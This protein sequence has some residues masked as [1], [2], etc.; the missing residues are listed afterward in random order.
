MGAEETAPQHM[1]S[2]I[3]CLAA[4]SFSR[5]RSAAG[6]RGAPRPAPPQGRIPSALLTLEV[7]VRVLVAALGLLLAVGLGLHGLPVEADHPPAVAGR[8]P[9]AGIPQPGEI[10]GGEAHQVGRPVP[11]HLHRVALQQLGEARRDLDAHGAGGTEE[12]AAA[13]SSSPPS[14]PA[15]G[16]SGGGL[17]P[18]S[19]GANWLP[20]LR[21]R[22]PRRGRWGGRTGR[23]LPVC[24]GAGAGAAPT[25]AHAPSGNGACVTL[26]RGPSGSGHGGARGQQCAC[27]AGAEGEA[28]RSRSV[29]LRALG[30]AT[31]AEA[32][33][34][35]SAAAV[36]LTVRDVCPDVLPRGKTDLVLFVGKK[37]WKAKPQPGVWRFKVLLCDACKSDL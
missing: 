7:G 5:R 25:A 11:Q 2:P 26:R 20:P 29:R 35:A 23:E 37:G 8:L 17:G 12:E 27:A 30:E 16:C 22:E 21:S 28:G 3:T 9:L 24:A 32:A 1:I 34:R 10:L 18:P 15:G 19:A 36:E 14:R 13:A 6:H 4:R 33:R 31:E